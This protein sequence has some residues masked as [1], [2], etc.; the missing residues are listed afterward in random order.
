MALRELAKRN[1]LEYI[2]NYTKDSYKRFLIY[3]SYSKEKEIIDL[4]L[5]KDS[6]SGYIKE[7][8]LKDIKANGE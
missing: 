8:I 4:L 5:T 1:K 6:I 2:K 7:L 3:V